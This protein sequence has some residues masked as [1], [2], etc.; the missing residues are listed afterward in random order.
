MVLSGMVST[1]SMGKSSSG[2]NV[3]FISLDSCVS[4]CNFSLNTTNYDSCFTNL[5]AV[6]IWAQFSIDVTVWMMRDRRYD[7]LNEHVPPTVSSKVTG[8]KRSADLSWWWVIYLPLLTLSGAWPLFSAAQLSV[9]QTAGARR[10]LIL[11]PKATILLCQLSHRLI[12]LE[13]R[14]VLWISVRH[15]AFREFL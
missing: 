10:S 6:E 4:N 5:F 13:W 2:D 1:S 8:D 9:V 12:T 14:H 15:K 3:D 11:W 7:W